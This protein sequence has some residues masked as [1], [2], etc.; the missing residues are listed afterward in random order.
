MSAI[1]KTARDIKKLN[2]RVYVPRHE[3]R[4]ADPRSF[5]HL[6]L[7]FYDR[8]RDALVGEGCTWL[9]DVEDV[10]LKGTAFDFRT[11]IRF[12]V[13]KDRTTC[14]GLYH[15]KPRIWVRLLLWI[16]RLKVGRTIDCESELS[17]GGYIVTS[18]A[19][20]ASKL[21]PPPGF[22]VRYFPVETDPGTVLRAHCQRLKDTLA[23]NPDIRATAMRT[24]EEAI[25]MQQ[26]MQT[27]KAAFRKG[28]GY[29][30]EDELERL[31]ANSHTAVEIK[32]AMNRS[33]NGA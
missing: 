6:D 7:S 27:A 32:Q 25:E 20:E 22:D 16:L 15:P 5:R 19:A 1:K 9:G 11:F 30:T 17:T 21:N 33:E 8:T 14:I 31:G 23:A 4:Q 24:S 10:T 26:R 28:I 13:S 18:S 3:Y 2:E 12:L 29:V